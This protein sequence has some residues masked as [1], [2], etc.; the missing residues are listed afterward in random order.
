MNYKV[1]GAIKK[2]RKPFIIS[3][4]LWVI[5]TIVFIVPLSYS[6]Y[7]AT[8]KG[9]FN[10]ELFMKMFGNAI[11][12]PFSVIGKII[13]K[14]AIGEFFKIEIGFTL[15][16]SIFFFIGFVKSAPKS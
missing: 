10:G 15:F 14:G 5:I 9:G 1:E 11:Q 3:V 7:A 6:V 12:R 8:Y 16:Y 4:I 2:N 13:E